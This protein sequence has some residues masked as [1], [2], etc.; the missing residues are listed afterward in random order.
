MKRSTWLSL[1]FLFSLAQ[2]F[3]PGLRVS[4][5]SISP[6]HGASR[7]ALAFQC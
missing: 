5:D 4:M 3:T 2:A 1:T 7:A 6:V